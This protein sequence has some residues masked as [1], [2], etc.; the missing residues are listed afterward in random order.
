MTE[1][2]AITDRIPGAI[3]KKKII[4]PTA[5]GP[6][7]VVGVTCPVSETLRM[8]AWV[9]FNF[10]GHLGIRGSRWANPTQLN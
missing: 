4:S 7:R 9:F 3:P 1:L 5:F 2:T 6:E 10:S 8:V